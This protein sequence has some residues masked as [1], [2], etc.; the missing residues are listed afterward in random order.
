[1]SV[2][3]LI[4]Q[5]T[6]FGI[7]DLFA[8]VGL[9][10]FFYGQVPNE[11][12]SVGL[13]LYLSIFG[14]GSLLSRYLVSFINEVTSGDGR[15]GWLVDNLDRAHLDYF[16]WL[17]AGLT[18]ASL[19]LFVYFARTHTYNRKV[20]KFSGSWAKKRMTVTFVWMLILYCYTLPQNVNKC[21]CM[22]NVHVSAN[23]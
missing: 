20:Q 16:Y 14:I 18:A 6:L 10:E 22:P 11:L 17:L 15:D 9:Q 1:M 5:N 23:P 12:R 4:P 21:T 2:W 3:W 8:M 13:S 7:A 19:V